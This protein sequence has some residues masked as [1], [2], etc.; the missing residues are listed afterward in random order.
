MGFYR[1]C[2][3]AKGYSRKKAD[4][5]T[6]SPYQGTIKSDN[7]FN[8]SERRAAC[9]SLCARSPSSAGVRHQPRLQGEL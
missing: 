2:L 7:C 4:E 8:V 3:M 6:V 9:V 1:D 5:E